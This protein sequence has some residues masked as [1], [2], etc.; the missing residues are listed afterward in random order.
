MTNLVRTL[1]QMKSADIG[2]ILIL[3]AAA[4]YGLYEALRMH[5]GIESIATLWLLA[6]GMSAATIRHRLK[7]KTAVNPPDLIL[8]WIFLLCAGGT[9]FLTAFMSDVLAMQISLLLVMAACLARFADYQNVF[10]LLPAGVIFLLLLP[11]A[12]YFNSLISYPLR[13][14]CSYLTCFT[15]KICT[16]DIS[17]EATMLQLGSKKI[18]VTAACSGINQL[19]AMFF[20]GWVITMLVHKRLLCRIAHWLLL[21]PIVILLNS[22]RLTITLLLYLGFGK[23]AFN[24]SVHVTLGYVMVFAVALV[25]WAC[26]SLIPF[27]E[28]KELSEEKQ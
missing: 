19:E 21:L 25:F 10:K 27:S 18:A 23:V 9:L 22:L 13:L 20:I 11:N 26:R 17:C 16:V 7:N 5:Q 28:K 2:F 12:D 1:K 15:L 14:I 3:L 4:A 6:A 24:E 8:S